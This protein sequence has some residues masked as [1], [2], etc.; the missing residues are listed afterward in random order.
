M[1]KIKVMNWNI[2]WG[3]GSV[4]NSLHHSLAFWKFLGMVATKKNVSKISQFIRTK[5]IDIVG[6]QEID[7]GSIRNRKFNQV[8]KVSD[9]T[10]LKFKKYA[11]E[12]TF[13]NFADDGN[14][15]ISRF[16]FKN[17]KIIDLPYN[18]E[19]RSLISANYKIKGKE[20]KVIVTHLGA[21]KFNKNERIQQMHT[22]SEYVNSLNIPVI[23]MGDFNCEPQ[24]R[25]F[26]LLL[27]KTNLKP[28]IDG[29]TYK[30]MGKDCKYDNILISPEIKVIESKILDVNLSD[31][32]P[33]YAELSI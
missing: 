16:N 10:E 9:I 28:L 25:E 8:D 31:H 18:K 27:T 26:K 3:F 15:L 4:K 23:L 17:I 2:F 11:P 7:N 12:K 19:K 32:K 5:Q 20:F 6:L 33:V 30:H 1:V 14:A 29:A 22:I 24:D 21:W 13:L